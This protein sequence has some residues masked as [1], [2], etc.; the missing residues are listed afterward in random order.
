MYVCMYVYIYTCMCVSYVF[1]HLFIYQINLFVINLFLT[2]I[3]VVKF[4]SDS[5]ISVIK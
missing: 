3:S 5:F 4:Y 2:F 1:F